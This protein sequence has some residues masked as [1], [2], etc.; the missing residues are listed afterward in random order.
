MGIVLGIAAVLA[1]QKAV[2][3]RRKCSLGLVLGFFGIGKP[4]QIGKKA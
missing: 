3:S 1:L 2:G 4:W